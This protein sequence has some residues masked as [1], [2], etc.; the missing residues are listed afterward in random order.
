MGG[1]RRRLHGF[2]QIRFNLK[3]HNMAK[4]KKAKTGV[5]KQ[6]VIIKRTPKKQGLV[7]K[8]D[9]PSPDFFKIILLGG[10]T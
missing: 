6:T 4:A 1:R 3:L 10:P 2:C 5:A 8:I 7:I 9:P